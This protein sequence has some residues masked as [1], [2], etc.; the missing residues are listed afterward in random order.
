MIRSLARRGGVIVIAL[1]LLAPPVLAPAELGSSV[2]AQRRR[3]GAGAGAGA[4]SS[5]TGAQGEAGFQEPTEERTVQA[6][7]AESEPG[8]ARSTSSSEASRED[9]TSLEE[10]LYLSERPDALG[11]AARDF[12]DE[13]LARLL[14]ERE[15]LLVERREQAIALLEEFIR[16]EPESAAEMPDA[17]LRLAELRWELARFRYLQAFQAWQAVPEENRGAEPAPDFRPAIELYDRIL[18]LHRDFG[19]YDFVLYMKAYALTELGQAEEALVLYHRI[20]DEFPNSRFVPDA[21]MAFAETHFANLDFT[22]ALP[23]FE[24]VMSFRDSELYNMALFKSAWCL[25]RLN[26]TT[27]AATRFRQVLDLGNAT[28]AL[29]ADQR[30]RLR[31]LQNEAL[32]YLIQVFTEDERNTARDVFRFLQEIGGE[33]YA[34]RVLT[35]LSLTYMDQARYDQG[36]DSYRLLLEM[37]PADARAPQWQHQI[38]SAY[39]AMDDDAHT[40]EAL[41]ALAQNYLAGSGW[42][43]QQ[44]DPEVIASART[45][46]ER[47]VRVRAMRWHELG[48]RAT[49]SDA[50]AAGANL[51]ATAR[52]RLEQAQAG[53][54]LYLRHFGEEPGAYDLHF[55]RAEILFHRLERYP[56]AGEEYLEAAHLRPDG[57]YTR[58]ALYNAIGAFEHVRE[59]Q[60]EE[61]QRRGGPRPAGAQGASPAG[62]QGASP[63]AAQGASPSGAGA[64][65]GQPASPT[66]ATTP[67]GDAAPAAEEDPCGETEND[68]QFSEAIEL[69]VQYFPTDPDLPEILFRQG[70][71]YYDRSV[72]DPAVRLFGQLLERFPTSSYATQA[73]ELI[74]DSFNRA[75]DFGNIEVW[76]RRLK[77]APAFQTAE[78]QRRL[79]TLILQA[80]FARGEQ[81][82]GRGEHREAAEAFEAAANEFPSDERARQALYNAGLERQRAGDL[83]GASSTYDRLIERYPG[84]TEGALGA[85]NGA[86]MFES[87]AQFRD[88]AHFYEAYGARFPSGEHAEDALFNATLLRLSAGDHDAAVVAAQ[89]FLERYPRSESADEVTFFQA[90]AHASARRWQDAARVYQEYVR[91]SRNVDRNVEAQARLAQ[92]WI[93]AGNPEEAGRALEQAVRA[94]RA[95]LRRLSPEGRFF[96]AQARYLQGEAILRDFEAI[97]I[98]GDVAGL[99]QR[100][101]RK[102]QLLRQA[103]E[104]FA[105]VVELRVAE[106]VT[107]ALYQVGHSYELFASGLRDAPVPTGLS[108]EEEQAYRDQL[109]YFI[110]PIEEQALEAYEGGYRTAI[111]LRIYNRWTAELRDGLT[112]LNDVQY[113]PLRELGGELREGARLAPM[114]PLDGLRRGAAL[115]RP[116]TT[117]PSE[118][119]AAPAAPTSNETPAAGTGSRR[120]RRRPR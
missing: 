66:T 44:T 113:P 21:H 1:A 117:A 85:W 75:Q 73:G 51:N 46:V 111:E 77:D 110:V 29:S 49:A 83:S 102:S 63:A 57:Q 103:A 92:V 112:R 47:A 2:H 86:Q 43:D 20:V 100:L 79:D 34:E 52:R 118:P 105:D 109:A 54:D 13:E 42:A 69:Y 72:F 39:A 35:R 30:R 23:E 60:L 81:L 58:D 114:Q 65:G 19:R 24:R 37:S 33:Q 32:D 62:A 15:G 97:T 116:T 106:W 25:W 12:A 70:R 98:D 3:R 22:R 71:L 10:R 84:S 28:A 55:Y 56:E 120:R 99:R 88:A 27:E 74:L 89:Q 91:R 59:N 90:R 9:T 6:P 78:Y 87:I 11:E 95:A 68:L 76:A 80:A 40:L 36:I 17:L 67:E 7:T 4:S 115:A 104:A 107:A 45:R 8:P 82:A 96:M 48:Q 119:T 108:E 61:C 18:T 38:A 31:E 41:T 14:A 50:E 101:E 94:G 53:Y 16:E 93:D 26:R 64:A 5:A